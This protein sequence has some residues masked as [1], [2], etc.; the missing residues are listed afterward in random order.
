VYEPVSQKI[1]VDL[2]R[3]RQ[4]L[5]KRIIHHPLW[6]KASGNTAQIRK[7]RDCE[8]SFWNLIF[9]MLLENIK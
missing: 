9:K 3:I 1:M 7:R 8:D 4:I 2:L 5:H 6:E